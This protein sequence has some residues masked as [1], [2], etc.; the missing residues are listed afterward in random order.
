MNHNCDP[1]VKRTFFNGKVI[2]YAVKHINK[3]EQVIATFVLI[4]CFYIYRTID[5]MYK[6]FISYLLAMVHVSI[7]KS[8]QEKKFYSITMILI[9]SVLFAKTIGLII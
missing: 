8:K 5:I 9:A 7:G 2:G 6:K 1:N 3:G 4:L